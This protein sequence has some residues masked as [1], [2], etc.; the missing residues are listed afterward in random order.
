MK[1]QQLKE[2]NAMRRLMGLELIAEGEEA[3]TQIENAQKLVLRLSRSLSQ[4]FRGPFASIV[5]DV[6]L[7]ICYTFFILFGTS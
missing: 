1:K 2:T 7:N 3:M 5:F 6:V 4:I